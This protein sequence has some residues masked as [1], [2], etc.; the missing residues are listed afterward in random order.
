MP[1]KVSGGYRQ[2]GGETQVLI[3]GVAVSEFHELI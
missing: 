2:P 1:G 3:L